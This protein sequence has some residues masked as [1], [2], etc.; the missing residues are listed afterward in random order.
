[1]KRCKMNTRKKETSHRF[2]KCFH[3][4]VIT[5]NSTVLHQVFSTSKTM[6]KTTSSTSTLDRG[7]TLNRYKIP[8]KHYGQVFLPCY[9]R[10]Q[11]DGCQQMKI[12]YHWPKE[13][14]TLIMSELSLGVWVSE[15]ASEIKMRRSHLNAPEICT[16]PIFS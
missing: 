5:P 15:L 14:S 4:T 16:N 9:I 11:V 8:H 13:I 10:I 1:M 6:H 2:R 7:Q 3:L 12:C